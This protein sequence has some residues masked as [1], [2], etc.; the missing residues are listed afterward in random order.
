MSRLAGLVFSAAVLLPFPPPLPPSQAQAPLQAPQ[1][2]GLD[3]LPCT[4]FAWNDEKNV[5]RVPLSMAGQQFSYQL[6][7]GADVVIPYGTA[8]HPGWIARHE[9]VRIPDVS[10]AGLHLPAILAYRNLKMP[11]TNLQGTVGL[12]LLVGHV[13]LIDFPRRRI[14]MFPKANLPEALDE[15]T[16]WS[17]AEIRHGKL[18]LS[19]ELR[20]GFWNGVRLGLMGSGL[21]PVPPRSG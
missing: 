16:D 11:D 3:T 21:L 7:T 1:K 9:G 18:F 15:A 14:C 12:D 13:F 20:A 5:M 17:P 6:D 2:L 10:F 8:Q 19:V 4:P